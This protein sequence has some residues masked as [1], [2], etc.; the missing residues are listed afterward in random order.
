MEKKKTTKK[1]VKKTVKKVIK[2]TVKR[3]SKKVAK[4]IVAKK[5]ILTITTD[6]TVGLTPGSPSAMLDIQAPAKGG[7]VSEDKTVNLQGTTRIVTKM[8]DFGRRQA[9]EQETDDNRFNAMANEWVRHFYGV[10][11]V[12]SM[13]NAELVA[14]LDK[15]EQAKLQEELSVSVNV[16][17]TA[18]KDQAVKRYGLNERTI[19]SIMKDARR[20]QPLPDGMRRDTLR[21]FTKDTL[22]PEYRNQTRTVRAIAAIR[23]TANNAW[24][25]LWNLW[26]WNG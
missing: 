16:V 10:K 3:T 23:H 4:K 6:G 14:A 26:H 5:D 20:I 7:I 17:H 13:N 21:G 15:A 9:V 18:D 8:T 22:K 25:A 24:T 12:R 2:K 1:V 11:A 19:G